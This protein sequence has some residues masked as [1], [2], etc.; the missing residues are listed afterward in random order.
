MPQVQFLPHLLDCLL[1]F[2][3]CLPPGVDL[4]AVHP[5]FWR[6]TKDMS[7]H[8]DYPISWST[9]YQTN[10]AKSALLL[11]PLG[12]CWAGCGRLG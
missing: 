8:P 9:K 12:E 1:Q 10:I 3:Q 7:P 4:A 11:M 6:T 2:L 5:R